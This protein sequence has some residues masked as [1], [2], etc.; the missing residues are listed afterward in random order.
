MNAGITLRRA[1]A[2]GARGRKQAGFERGSDHARQR[3][4]VSNRAQLSMAIRSSARAGEPMRLE[5]PRAVVSVV[6]RILKAEQCYWDIF[7]RCIRCRLPAFLPSVMP[8][9]RRVTGLLPVEPAGVNSLRDL[10]LPFATA[11]KVVQ[12]M[13]WAALA[14]A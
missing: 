4:A 5:T 2:H 10:K 7:G 3:P 12:Q 9:Q 8:N 11:G 1:V 14:R 13:A 6:P